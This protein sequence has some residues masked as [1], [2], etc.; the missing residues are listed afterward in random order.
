MRCAKCG[1]ALQAGER[2]CG[3]CGTTV[4]VVTPSP[5]A[6]P[7]VTA[8]YPVRQSVTPTPG[9]RQP[10]PSPPVGDAI[11][12]LRALRNRRTR[13]R[14]APADAT[15]GIPGQPS[16]PVRPPA[17]ERVPDSAPK[18]SRIDYSGQD[19]RGRDLSGWD[20]TKATLIGVDLSGRDVS[21]QD[22]SGANLTY[23]DLTGANLGGANLTGA[24]LTGVKGYKPWWRLW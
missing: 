12:R 23:A 21:G 7:P 13:E 20:L 18:R 8:P 10:S 17:P 9:A 22:L 2:F 3:E 16:D 4:T 14:L 1:N 11:A 15:Q 19:L 6:V 24:N 5:I